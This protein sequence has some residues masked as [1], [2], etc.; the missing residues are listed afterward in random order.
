MR[1]EQGW[2]IYDDPEGVRD[3]LERAAKFSCYALVNKLVF[4]E[5]LLKRY[6]GQ[7]NK[8]VVPEHIDTGR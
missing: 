3:N 2:L 4:H 8:I 6:Q 7:L 5:A 1:D